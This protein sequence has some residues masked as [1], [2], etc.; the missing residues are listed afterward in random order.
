MAVT[1]NITASVLI[2]NYANL[3]VVLRLLSNYFL[4]IAKLKIFFSYDFWL[5]MQNAKNLAFL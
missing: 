5:N 3:A 1:I 2:R 4:V